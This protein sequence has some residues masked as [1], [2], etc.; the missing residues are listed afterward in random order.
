MLCL[1]QYTAPESFDITLDRLSSVR[2]FREAV[3]KRLPTAHLQSSGGDVLLVESAHPNCSEVTRVLKDMLPLSRLTEGSVIYAYCPP[4]EL[5][6][7]AIVFQVK[8]CVELF[9]VF[10]LYDFFILFPHF[11]NPVNNI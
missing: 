5:P 2:A 7:H 8:G 10:A 6:N 3:S 9:E 1:M 11:G 4:S